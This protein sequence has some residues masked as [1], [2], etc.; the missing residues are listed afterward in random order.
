LGQEDRFFKFI[1]G[2]GEG[3]SYYVQKLQA[4][5]CVWGV[6]YLPHDAAHHRQQAEKTKSPLEELE[7]MQLGGRWEIVNRVDDINHGIQATRKAFSTSFFDEEGCKEGLAHLAAYRKEW[8][9]RLGCW[10]LKPRHDEHSEAADAY[11]QFG[12]GYTPAKTVPGK[13]ARELNWRT[14]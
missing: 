5:G 3:Y 4:M 14:V 9:E 8:N 2:W 12:Q 1:E 7:A 10:S 11:R 13:K 6:H